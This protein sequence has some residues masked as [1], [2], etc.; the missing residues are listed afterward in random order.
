[1]YAQTL[2]GNSGITFFLFLMLSRMK[3]DE[4]STTGA[5]II[6]ILGWLS[7]CGLG[8]SADN[9]GYTYME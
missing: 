1:M 9:R 6:W 7:N 5:A 4:I 2:C 8:T 3:V